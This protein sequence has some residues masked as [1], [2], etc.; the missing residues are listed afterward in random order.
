MFIF[1]LLF[2]V[3]IMP[4]KALISEHRNLHNKCIFITTYAQAIVFYLLKFWGNRFICLYI[5]FVRYCQG[6]IYINKHLF[7]LKAMQK[8][9]TLLKQMFKCAKGVPIW[10]W[11]LVVIVSADPKR[12]VL[13]LNH[14]QPSPTNIPTEFSS[15]VTGRARLVTWLNTAN[16][17][18]HMQELIIL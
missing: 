16:I 10:N 18:G 4:A 15:V 3:K 11:S 6:F 14:Q 8:V 12:D 1:Y 7:L 13:S 5:K 17:I 2:Y 9:P